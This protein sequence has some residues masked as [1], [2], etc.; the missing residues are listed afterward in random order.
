MVIRK[1]G[2]ALLYGIGDTLSL[3][4]CPGKGENFKAYV[5]IGGGGKER[6]QDLVS[7]LAVGQQ[8]LGGLGEGHLRTSNRW[9]LE[10]W[11]GYR[12]KGGWQRVEKSEGWWWVGWE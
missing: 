10:R 7:F 11:V 8:R 5:V 2:F 12:R 6:S 1:E 9:P 4:T 3:F